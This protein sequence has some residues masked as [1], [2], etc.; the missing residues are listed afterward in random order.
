[1]ISI[2]SNESKAS[3]EYLMYRQILKKHA[4]LSIQKY[5]QSKAFKVSPDGYIQL[6]PDDGSLISLKNSLTRILWKKGHE[7][8]GPRNMLFGYLKLFN[9]EK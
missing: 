7:R 2:I 4:N 3:G 5:L 1:M 6:Q 8:D 9:E